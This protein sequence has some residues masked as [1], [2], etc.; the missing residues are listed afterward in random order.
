MYPSLVL[1]VGCVQSYWNV[2]PNVAAVSRGHD[3][4]RSR[5]FGGRTPIPTRELGSNVS[6]LSA[7]CGSP[8]IR[9]HIV[10]H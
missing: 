6:F 7:A 1:N 10:P 4:L 5:M 2:A 3:M 8:F 9:M